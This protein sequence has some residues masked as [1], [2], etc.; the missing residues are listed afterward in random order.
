MGNGLREGY[1][2]Q[3]D[4]RME[5]HAGPDLQ[6]AFAENRLEATGHALRCRLLSSPGATRRGA[7]PGSSE[8]RPSKEAPPRQGFFE[9]AQLEAARRILPVDL[10][11]AVSVAYT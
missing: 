11:V 4:G 6:A 5:G 10:Q 8:A 9:R 1:W 2:R 3:T 7:R